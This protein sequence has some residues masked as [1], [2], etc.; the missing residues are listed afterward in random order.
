MQVLD[1]SNE[2]TPCQLSQLRE[3]PIGQ[4]GLCLNVP[5]S[6]SAYTGIHAAELVNVENIGVL[7]NS[8]QT[9]W[10]IAASLLF[11]FRVPGTWRLQSRSRTPRTM[12]VPE[13][14]RFRS[15]SSLLDRGVRNMGCAAVLRLG[16]TRYRAFG[17]RSKFRVLLN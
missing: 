14:I 5:V 6:A 13:S 1:K 9:S 4:R 15:N 3:P 8:N 10:T 12:V 17:Y 11:A 16:S 2:I 7:R